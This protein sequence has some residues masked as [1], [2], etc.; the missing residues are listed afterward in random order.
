MLV[1]TIAGTVLGATLI[2]TGTYFFLDLYR[3]EWN[4]AIVAGIVFLAA[5]ILAVWLLLNNRLSRVLAHA[6]GPS[7]RERQIRDRLRHNRSAGDSRAFA[8]LAETRQNA[9]VFVPILLGAG[10]VLSGLAW[11]VERVARATAGFADDPRIAARLSRLGPP[12]GG[13]LDDHVNPQRQLM[14]PSRR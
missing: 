10:L 1:R 4:R 3:W 14:G 9:G 7:N 2:G 12:E 8:W 13:L 6:G 11:L 5:E